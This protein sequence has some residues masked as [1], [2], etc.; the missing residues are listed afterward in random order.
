M[1]EHR[2]LKSCR[3]PETSFVTPTIRN[4]TSCSTHQECMVFT[5]LELGAEPDVQPGTI[6]RYDCI[7]LISS[8]CDV[9]IDCDIFWS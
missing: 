7:C 9:T 3:P 4:E 8:V 2:A 1:S 6:V 5:M